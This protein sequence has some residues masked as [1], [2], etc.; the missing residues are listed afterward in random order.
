MKKKETRKIKK[1]EEEIKKKT[2]KE[3][4]K[5]KNKEK[6]MFLKG[7]FIEYNS[8]R[9]QCFSPTTPMDNVAHCGITRMDLGR[10]QVTQKPWRTHCQ[11]IGIS[12]G[13]CYVRAALMGR[14]FSAPRVTSYPDRVTTHRPDWL[15]IL[16][17][18]GRL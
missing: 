1:K 7:Y 2:K 8:R 18:P 12:A 9:S 3:N 4:R 6:K 14:A 13:S 10:T 17:M 11:W 5:Q 16:Q 15:H